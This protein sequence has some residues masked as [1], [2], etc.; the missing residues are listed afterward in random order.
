MAHCTIEV[1]LKNMAK[2]VWLQTTIWN[3]KANRVGYAQNTN[4][5][6][7]KE[8]QNLCLGSYRTS[9]FYNH[10]MIQSGFMLKGL[11]NKLATS[12]EPKMQR[13]VV[14]NACESTF[15]YDVKTQIYLV[16][17]FNLI[18]HYTIA[19]NVYVVE[20]LWISFVCRVQKLESC[21]MHRLN[22][23]RLKR[24]WLSVALIW[25]H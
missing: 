1:I 15:R 6:W 9:W 25:N 18:Q 24:S 7:F 5:L 13:L 12:F 14:N 3:N 8:N 22:F 16:A 11:C 17:I 20:T 19:M 2:I 21:I 4:R 23:S 10:L